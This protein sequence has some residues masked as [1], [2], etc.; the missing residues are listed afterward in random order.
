M[1]TPEHIILVLALAFGFYMAWS[2][3]A[4]D[5]ANAMGTSVGSGALTLK[6]AIIIAAILEFSGAFFVGSNVT[7]TVRK[8]I[9]DPSIFIHDPMLFMLGMLSALLAAAAWL[10]LASYFGWPVS[11][12]HSIVGAIVGFGLITGGVHAIKW[13]KLFSITMSWVISPIL[14]AIIAFVVFNIIRYKVYFS[15]HPLKS[16]KK[17]APYLI[18]SVFFVLTLAMVFKGLKNL[19]LHLT[20]SKACFVAILVGIISAVIGNF[21]I[22][23]TPGLNEIEEIEE[24]DEKSA[25]FLF[26]IY[27][28]TKRI[29]NAI[30]LAPNLKL[31]KELLNILHKIKPIVGDI[32]SKEIMT[33][34]TEYIMVE[35]IFGYLQIL[36]ASFVAFAHGANDV[37]NS[38]GPL[39]GIVSV[40]KTGT[41]VNKSPVP[42]WVLALGGLGIVIGLATWGWRVIETVGKRITE[43]TP[44]RGFS[45]EFS[46]AIT[47]VFASKLGL[48]ISTTHTLVGAVLG[49]G[50]A[51]GFS[52]LN[53]RVV[54]DI[55][56]SWAITIPT[57]AI[58][59]ILIFKFLKLFF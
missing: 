2:I 31:K 15:P 52:A 57:G 22:G 29:E 41:V 14:S 36:S 46:A 1:I 47:I 49:V 42:L 18:F 38:V 9:I 8:G 35:K 48:P 23:R 59:T 56:I 43:L 5:V 37:A 10:Q 32:E 19:H 54:R 6:K 53:F 45:A 40:L 17:I 55:I 20:F 27:R 4:N 44:S 7:E 51:R 26:N 12:T 39:A 3:G 34:K 30:R 11:T 58:L 28:A 13:P 50:M 16:T 25:R 33:T 24:Y 21:L